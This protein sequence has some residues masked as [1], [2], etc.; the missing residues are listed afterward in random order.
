MALPYTRINPVVQSI[1]EG[2]MKHLD[3]GIGVPHRETYYWIDQVEP[4]DIQY[5]IIDDDKP[6][7]S[8]RPRVLR[9][10]IRFS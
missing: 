9:N 1:S 8:L 6:S 4:I 10:A 5:L 7:D 3:D 2:S